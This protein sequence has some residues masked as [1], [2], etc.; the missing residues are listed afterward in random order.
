MKIRF[1]LLTGLGAICFGCA[2]PPEQDL[3]ALGAASAKAATASAPT[4]VGPR[5]SLTGSRLPPLDDDDLGTSY[6]SGVTGEDY[7]HNDA[8]RVKIL[9]GGD[10]RACFGK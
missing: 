8:T 4:R 1:V 2:T 3:A 6:V 9:C 10:P 5:A 7:R